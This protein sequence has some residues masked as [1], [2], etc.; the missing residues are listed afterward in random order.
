MVGLVVPCLLSLT[1]MK[2]F[3]YLYESCL[4]ALSLKSII[5]YSDPKVDPKVWSSALGNI[6]SS[7]QIRFVARGGWESCSSVVS[8][9]CRFRKKV[10]L[11]CWNGSGSISWVF[12]F[13]Y[14]RC[15]MKNECLP[16]RAPS[17]KKEPS[18][19][20]HAIPSRKGRSQGR[21]KDNSYGIWCFPS[22]CKKVF[23]RNAGNERWGTWTGASG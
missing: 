12:T 9:C 4:F 11:W 1:Y 19:E 8:R 2:A 16:C 18:K 23:C 14:T 22:L 6:R 7:T 15:S 20:G 13:I 17:L 21:G 10:E 5:L 3:P